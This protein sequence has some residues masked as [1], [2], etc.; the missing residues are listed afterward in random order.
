MVYTKSVVLL[1]KYGFLMRWFVAFGL[2][3]S[4]VMV[5]LTKTGLLLRLGLPQDL[6]LTQGHWLFSIPVAYSHVS[7]YSQFPWF[8]LT[9][10]FFISIMI[11]S[12]AMVL[13]ERDGSLVF[14]GCS[15]K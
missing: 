1:L 2:N 4:K 13:L 14:G 11:H 7:G 10:W 6:W 3:P 8:T 15:P 12:T 5:L 9:Y